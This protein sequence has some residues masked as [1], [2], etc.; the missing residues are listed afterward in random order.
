[1][2]IKVGAIPPW[3]PHPPCLWE[4]PLQICMNDFMDT[5]YLLSSIFYLLSSISCL[6]QI[7]GAIQKKIK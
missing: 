7:M 4:L 2:P 6:L 1:L 5:R 3:L